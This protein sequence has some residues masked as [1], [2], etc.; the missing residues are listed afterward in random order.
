MAQ[1]SIFWGSVVVAVA[2]FGAS[3]PWSR[4]PPPCDAVP[5]AQRESARLAGRCEGAAPIYEIRS[6]RRVESRGARRPVPDLRGQQFDAGDERLGRFVVAVDYRPSVQQRNWVLDQ[7]PRPPA[8]LPEGGDLTLVLSDGTLV[9][10]PDV[11]GGFAR[12]LTTLYRAGLSWTTGESRGGRVVGQ[13]PEPGATVPSGTRVV[14]RTAPAQLALAPESTRPEIAPARPAPPPAAAPSPSPAPSS[15]STAPMRP[16][17]APDAGPSGPSSRAAPSRMPDLHG[18]IFDV[19]RQRLPGV[20]VE[21]VLRAGTEAGGTVIGQTPAPGSPLAPGTVVRLSLSDGSLIRVPRVRSFRLDEARQRLAPGEL[22]VAITEVPSDA[23][24]GTV[25]SQQP[26]EGEI[27]ARGSAVRLGVSSGPAAAPYVVVPN[28]VGAPLERARTQLGKAPV[29]LS[30]RAAR[31]PVGTVLE[32]TP[33]PGTRVAPGAT[34]SIVVSS[35]GR[36]EVIELPDVVG[37]GGDE[38]VAALS[39]FRVER[40]TV[41]GTAPPGRVLAQQPASGTPVA[42]GGVVRLRISDGSRVVAP[43]FVRMTLAEARA[44]G[45]AGGLVVAPSDSDDAAL[46]T[47]QEPP[48]GTEVARG[49]AVRLVVDAGAAPFALPPAL[50]GAWAQAADTVRAQPPRNLLIAIVVALALALLALLLVARRRARAPYAAIE[51]VFAPPPAF[52]PPARDDAPRISPLPA[53]PA[54]ESPARTR[55]APAVPPI[56]RRRDARRAAAAVGAAPI[57]RRGDADRAAAAIAAASEPA[58][59]RAVARLDADAARTVALHVVPLGPE[60]RI[61]A[62]LEPG[63]AGVRELP[64]EPA[65]DELTEETR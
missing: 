29:A 51:P 61:A 10:V 58:S 16:A 50:R 5:A 60:I 42:P 41:P 27:A 39:E 25:V 19:A 18:L 48:P 53:E 11:R 36:P 65:A 20:E 62:R 63:V 57:V 15:P 1:R 44:A 64:P 21:R 34:V 22:R 54:S 59:F 43:A 52:T 28:L 2:L 12:A 37:R 6:G 35:G 23:P 30:E 3:A 17:P 4:T 24:A 32:Q 7:V 14:L 8:W 31:E 26:A 55:P 33:A 40:E 38:A 47:A 13:D 45:R 49:S 56:V 46:V 9:R